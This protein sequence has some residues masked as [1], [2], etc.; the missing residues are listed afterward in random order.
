MHTQTD[1]N[2]KDVFFDPLKNAFEQCKNKRCCLEFSDWDF[3]V[4]GVSRVLSDVRSGR[5]F[6]Q[7]AQSQYQQASISVGRFFDALS[8]SRRTQLVSELAHLLRT[9]LDQ[10]IKEFDRLSQIEALSEFEVYATDGHCHGSSAHE[11]AIQG[12]KRATNHIFSLNLRSQSLSLLCSCKPDKGKKKK[13]EITAL[14]E[15]EGSALRMGHGKGKKVIHV[16]DPAIVDYRQWHKWKQGRGIYIITREKDNS[17]LETMAEP[18]YDHSDPLNAGVQCDEFVGSSCSGEMLRRVTYQAPETGKIFRFITNEMRLPP[19][20]I[21][22]LY[23]MRWDV[24]KVFDQTK[25]K[26]CEKQSWT[27]TNAG[28][29][30][31][32]CFMAMTHNLM[33]I[34]ERTLERT[35]NIRD[36][37]ALKKRTV[38]AK[39]QQCIAR[40]AQRAFNPFI[41]SLSRPTQR[42]LQFIRWLRTQFIIKLPWRQAIEQLGPLMANYIT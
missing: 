6:V 2:V 17:A 41:L 28:K 8:S 27:K 5:D 21:A 16:Y 1:S 40:D 18:G 33:L 23:K 39:K 12:K 36:E 38:R 22:L 35:E 4:S 11:T 15:L 25:N 34:L 13:H 30:Q 24:E 26:L 19:G 3:L 32:A 37:L 42:S 31:Q 14:K 10:G 7:Q 20:V 9:K 29:K